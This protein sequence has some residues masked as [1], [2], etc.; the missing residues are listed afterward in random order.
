MTY[1][2]QSIY[3]YGSGRS[4]DGLGRWDTGIRLG[5]DAELGPD[6][7]PTGGLNPGS[8]AG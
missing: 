5:P 1:I 4:L 7:G 3:T 2:G 8:F 6:L